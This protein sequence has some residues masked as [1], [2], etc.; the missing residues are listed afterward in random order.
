MRD[1]HSIDEQFRLALANAEVEPPPKVL[2]GVLAAQHSKRK[3]WF[4]L[5]WPALALVGGGMAVAVYLVAGSGQG[6]NAVPPERTV[7]QMAGPVGAVLQEGP[8]PSAAERILESAVGQGS[9]LH[10]GAQSSNEHGMLESVAASS[11]DHAR[12]EENT[13]LIQQV[14]PKLIGGTSSH[15]RRTLPHVESSTTALLDKERSLPEQGSVPIMLSHDP[16]RAVDVAS[17]L[18]ATNGQVPLVRGMDEEQAGV[19]APPETSVVLITETV[20]GWLPLRPPHPFFEASSA[21]LRSAPR[22]AHTYV[23]PKGEWWLGPTAGAYA[24]KLRWSGEDQELASRIQENS[25]T[26]NNVAWGFAAGH[27]WRSGWGIS[28]GLMIEQ[29]SVQRQLT[30]RLILVEREVRTRVVTLDAMVLSSVSDTTITTTIIDTEFSGQERSTVLRVPLVAHW[31]GT[32]GRVLFGG[33]VGIAVEHARRRGGPVLVRN[34]A[35]ARI[36]PVLDEGMIA[37]RRSPLSLLA[38]VGIEGGYQLHEHW[39]LWAGPVTFAGLAAMESAPAVFAL[40]DSWGL[41]VRLAHHLYRNRT[42]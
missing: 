33:H 42:P 3:H 16:H 1:K 22:P 17:P 38:T 37:D 24:S 27:T 20:V 5:F 29:G 6:I 13:V 32:K 14:E 41:Q 25:P 30:D 28:M 9:Q 11:Q 36:A 39:S 21:E 31:H 12:K 7:R 18:S 19:V 35:D 15:S 34:T 23:L 26:R 4:F 40:P 2:V 10:K 8:Q